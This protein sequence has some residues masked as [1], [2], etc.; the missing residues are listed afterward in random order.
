MDENVEITH[1]PEPAAQIVT[2][3]V[4]TESKLTAPLIEHEG[5][6][7]RIEERQGQMQE[8][9]A[10]ALAA[11][12][13]RL[14]TATGSQIGVLERRIAEIESKQ[15]ATT[16]GE[17]LGEMAGQGVDLALPDVE[18]S[19]APPEKIR[20]GMRHRRKAKRKGEK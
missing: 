5:R 12:E 14:V 15:A 8:E 17:D 9:H 1:V 7:V 2:P 4:E 10:R 11:L 6:V 19:P 13:E 18:V 16:E 20:Q 3:V